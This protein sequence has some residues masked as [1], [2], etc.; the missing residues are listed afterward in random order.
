M[1]GWGTGS[2][3]KSQLSL[4]HGPTV[5]VGVTVTVG[6]AVGVAVGV[7]VGST[8]GASSGHAPP[9]TCPSTCQLPGAVTHVEGNALR[10]RV[11][12]SRGPAARSV[13]A[14]VPVDVGGLSTD[15]QYQRP[16]TTGTPAGRNAVFQAPATGRSTVPEPSSEPGLL[17]ASV[18]SPSTRREA[19]LDASTHRRSEFA[20]PA[21]APVIW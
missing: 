16:G 11:C 5:G 3:S 18:Y 14:S 15:S 9:D 1:A 17:L 19:R 13:H 6:V 2:N 4:R 7:G 12:P 21:T 20:V 8:T 10:S